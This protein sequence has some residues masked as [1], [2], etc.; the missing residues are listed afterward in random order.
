MSKFAAPAVSR[1]TATLAVLMY[2][3]QKVFLLSS[4]ETQIIVFRTSGT[5]LATR[6]ISSRGNLRTSVSLVPIKGVV[7]K[8]FVSGTEPSYNWCRRQPDHLVI[9]TTITIF[10][11]LVGFGHFVV[12]VRY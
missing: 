11:A 10:H 1:A 8:L 5:K 12:F 4:G 3:Y 6:Y 2:R 9:A 7:T